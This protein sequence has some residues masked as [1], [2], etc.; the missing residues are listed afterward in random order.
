VSGKPKMSKG[1]AASSRLT[2]PGRVQ[3]CRRRHWDR[4]EGNVVPVDDL[5]DVAGRAISLGV[6]ELACRLSLDAHSFARAAKNLLAAAQL[7]VGEESLRKLVESEGKLA[8]GAQECEQ[9]EFDWHAS[10]CLT[11]RTA[12]K[13]Q[14]TRLY[15]GCDGVQV[16]TIRDAEKLKRREAAKQR[17]RR[18]PRRRGV[19]RRPLPAV[20]RGSDQTWKEFKIVSLYDQERKR[21]LVRG[22]RKNHRHAG[23]LMRQMGAMVRWRGARQKIALVDG[24][25]WI[26][27]QIEQNLA[28]LDALTLDCFHLAEHVHQT[29]REVF[30]EEEES[31]KTWAGQVIETIKQQG[32]EPMWQK[33][34]ELRCRRRSRT[35]CAA[36]DAL[37]HYVAERRTMLDYPR[38]QQEGWDIGSGPTESMCKALTRRIKG[39]G[40][41]WDADNAEA[42]MALEALM[43]SD[44]WSAW[45]QHR[46]K[47]VTYESP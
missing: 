40:M 16:P 24:A 34:V 29:R 31:G 17:R 5:I 4:Q 9:L 11:Q 3:L 13:G 44:A 30:G 46:L 14:T 32:Y 22:T 42:M 35:K 39:R 20:K 19:R 27:R 47:S 33:L 2:L 37:M 41:R 45:W 1:R 8:L 21:R 25:E 38:H 28:G 18:L 10:D 36:I 7:R 43:Q 6:R 26:R 12:G 23:K 15:V